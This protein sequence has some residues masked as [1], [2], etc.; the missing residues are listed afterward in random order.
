MKVKFYD[1]KNF[2]KGAKVIVPASTFIATWL[3]VSE[4]GLEIV[5]V[6]VSSKT[7][8]LD[9]DLA[10]KAISEDK[11]IKAVIYVHLYGNKD[12]KLI[13]FKKNIDLR[14]VALIEDA[15]QAH[16][17]KVGERVAGSIGHAAAFSFYP[18]K[19]LGALGDA[20][21]ITS[22]D[23][24][25]I[26]SC[27]KIANYGSSEKYIHE[28][29]GCN[30]RLDPI[31]AM[32]LDLKLRGV[33]DLIS[34]RRAIAKLYIES[35]FSKLDLKPLIDNVEDSVFHQFIIIAE[36]R[37]HFISYMERVGI[38]TVIHYPEPPYKQKCYS[39]L[40][41]DENLFPVSEELSNKVISIPIGEFLTDEEVQYISSYLKEYS[42]E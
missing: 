18:S 31:Q 26:N 25:L 36:N 28:E 39:D 6:E 19:N 2:P 37:E 33:E 1:L 14:G 38:Q 5:P 17:L 24:S 30:S 11:N 22:N 23:E 34:R 16:G 21:A 29:L 10:L 9:L 20:G 12:E 8:N 32:V 42:Y 27:R 40:G 15:A 3:A 7:A 41:I 35:L 4:C 13:E